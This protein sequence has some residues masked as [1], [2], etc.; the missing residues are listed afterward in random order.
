M[1][2]QK[3]LTT[4]LN[5]WRTGEPQL[6][7]INPVAGLYPDRSSLPIVARMTGLSFDDLIGEIIAQAAR[8]CGLC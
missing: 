5:Q 4:L 3:Q 2:Q 1:A 7:E 6:L 8:R